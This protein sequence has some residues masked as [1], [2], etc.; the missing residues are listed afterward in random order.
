[1]MKVRHPEPAVMEPL[2]TKRIAVA[3]LTLVVFAL[4]F[5]PFP[6]TIT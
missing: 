3:I 1:M 5:C 4:C 2:G 6:I